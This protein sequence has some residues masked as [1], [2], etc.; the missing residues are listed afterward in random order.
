MADTV[1]FG[2]MNFGLYPF[3]PL[4]GSR[5]KRMPRP[6]QPAWLRYV[7]ALLVTSGAL[8]GK[9]L[10]AR[11]VTR[12]EPVLLFFAAILVSAAFGGLGPG[13]L[14]TTVSAIADAYFFMRPFN[15]WELDS[16]DQVVRLAT[17]VIEG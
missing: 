14:A 12:D 17:F 6:R 7:V 8:T 3:M 5:S 9:L 15:R 1:V 10:L 4:R 13:L 16:A 2:G 11:L